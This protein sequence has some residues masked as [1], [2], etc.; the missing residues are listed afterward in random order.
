MN[1]N[2]ATSGVHELHL[3]AEAGALT[4]VSDFMTGCCRSFGVDADASFAVGLAVDEATTN[5]IE[6]GYNGVAGPIDLRCWVEQCDLFIELRDQGK[7][8]HPADAPPPTLAGP[9]QRRRA[10][11]LGLHFMRQLMD[12]IEFSRD[13]RGNRL[14]M[15]KRGVAP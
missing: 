2:G 1:R 15:I 14:L 13:E 9:L 7:R 8:F 12:E 4:L 10:G 6:H 11:G 5:I 3:D